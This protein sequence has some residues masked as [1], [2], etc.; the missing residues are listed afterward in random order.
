MTALLLAIALA[1]P[2]QERLDRFVE[3]IP[4]LKDRMLGQ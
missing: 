4:D 2:A 3:Q 1:A